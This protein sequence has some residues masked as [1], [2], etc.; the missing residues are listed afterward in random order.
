MSGKHVTIGLGLFFALAVAIWWLASTTY[1]KTSTPESLQLM[2]ALYTA[3]S[4]KNE[5]RLAKVE[6]SLAEAFRTQQVTDNERIAFESI[7]DVAKKGD[8][9]QAAQDSYRFAA[10]QLN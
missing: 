9:K 10:D 4:S 6:Q 7:I 5:T 8:W 3:C 2:R 1:P